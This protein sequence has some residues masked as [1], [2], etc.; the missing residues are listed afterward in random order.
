MSYELISPLRRF[1][2]NMVHLFLELTTD[3]R[4]YAD[5][6]IM[7]KSLQIHIW[8]SSRQIS[9]KRETTLNFYHWVSNA[10]VFLSISPFLLVSEKIFLQSESKKSVHINQGRNKVF[11]RERVRE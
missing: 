7:W 1:S 8:T 5:L 4:K 6:H 10:K 2:R 11:C 3:K 9:S